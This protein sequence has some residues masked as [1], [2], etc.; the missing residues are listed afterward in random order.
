MAAAQHL[1]AASGNH[2]LGMGVEKV[3]CDLAVLQ[4]VQDTPGGHVLRVDTQGPFR[5]ILSEPPIA[6]GEGHAGQ[7]R[8]RHRVRRIQIHKLPVRTL[9]LYQAR[10]AASDLSA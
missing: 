9:G 8:E 1:Q 6:S 10:R 4:H 5:E 2:L 3:G 7:A